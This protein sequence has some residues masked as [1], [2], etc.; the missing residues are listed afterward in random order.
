MCCA[1]TTINDGATSGYALASAMEL[2]A[3]INVA[4][5]RLDDTLLPQGFKMFQKMPPPPANSVWQFDTKTQ[6]WS[7]I[8]KSTGQAVQQLQ[9]GIKY[10]LGT[11]Y[12][13]T[14]WEVSSTSSHCK[15]VKV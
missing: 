2:H 6:I 7:A 13:P 1:I 14:G 3:R 12:L 15:H 4:A 5:E 8:S 10:V 9:D 11:G